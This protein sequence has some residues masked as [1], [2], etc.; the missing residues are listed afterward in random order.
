M[1]DQ[2]ARHDG[3]AKLTYKMNLC[4]QSQQFEGQNENHLVGE[5]ARRSAVQCGHIKAAGAAR[6]GLCRYNEG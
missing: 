6:A 5:R 4:I 2:L 1:F 3:P